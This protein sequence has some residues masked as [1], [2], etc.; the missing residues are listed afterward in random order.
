MIEATLGRLHADLDLAGLVQPGQETE[1]NARKPE[2]VGQLIVPL[3]ILEL[4]DVGAI[5]LGKI[6]IIIIVRFEMNN[7]YFAIALLAR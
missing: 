2:L 3:Y 7:M 1:D 6:I 5:D 4:V